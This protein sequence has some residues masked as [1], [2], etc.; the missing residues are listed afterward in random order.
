MEPDA[1]ASFP[2]RLVV[3]PASNCYATTM[4]STVEIPHD[5][6]CLVST[7]VVTLWLS[8]IAARKDATSSQSTD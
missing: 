2:M 6:G 7:G 3:S 1:Y 4:S 8:D 5:Q